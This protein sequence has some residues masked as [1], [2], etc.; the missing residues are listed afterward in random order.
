MRAFLETYQ[1][2]SIAQIRADFDKRLN[3]NKDRQ[4]KVG[5]CDYDVFRAAYCVQPQYACDHLANA[6]KAAFQQV[7]TN[8]LPGDVPKQARVMQQFTDFRFNGGH[9]RGGFNNA[10]HKEL[11]NTYKATP[12]TWWKEYACMYAEDLAEVA[13][14]I[15]CMVPSSSSAERNWSVHGWIHSKKRNRLLVKNANKLVYV[16][17]NLRLQQEADGYDTELSDAYWS[18]AESSDE[19]EAPAAEN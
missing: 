8:M 11:R 13:S 17:W 15:L 7:V 5:I 2:P 6:E 4:R 9:G 16:H 14:K 10:L 19:E 18:E 1:C 3:L 12:A